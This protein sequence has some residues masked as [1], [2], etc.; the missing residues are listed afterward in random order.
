MVKEMLMISS[1]FTFV[2][3]RGNEQLQATLLAVLLDRVENREK[4]ERHTTKN[5]KR[6][7]ENKRER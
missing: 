6:K 5:P 1:L 3:E 2:P 7:R 4:K